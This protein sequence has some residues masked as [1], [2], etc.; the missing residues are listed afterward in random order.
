MHV[1]R[2][3]VVKLNVIKCQ[4]NTEIQKGKSKESTPTTSGDQ[5]KTNYKVERWGMRH[6]C[7]QR[8]NLEK[9]KRLY[10]LWT[11]VCASGGENNWTGGGDVRG[12]SSHF[13]SLYVFLVCEA[14]S[15]SPEAGGMCVCGGWGVCV[16]VLSA[17]Q[18]WEIITL[19]SLSKSSSSSS[20]RSSTAC[21]QMQW[22]EKNKEKEALKTL[23][24]YQI[25]TISMA[26]EGH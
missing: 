18:T 8:E 16:C 21:W 20:S 25:N 1:P 7:T 14:V 2:K 26:K 6:A 15:T 12:R 11:C 17:S 24:K 13:V 9:V 3:K 4:F 22:N 10:N 23:D 19:S 5:N